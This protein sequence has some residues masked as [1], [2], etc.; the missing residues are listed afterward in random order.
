METSGDDPVFAAVAAAVVA[1]AGPAAA[2]VVVAAERDARAA[3]A[4]CKA[5]PVDMMVS[6]KD[7]HCVKRLA[8]D[9]RSGTGV[10][11][12]RCQDSC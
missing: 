4:A 8:S 11:T 10:S 1:A 7:V 3:Y 5:R 12:R 6:S 9:S 2:A